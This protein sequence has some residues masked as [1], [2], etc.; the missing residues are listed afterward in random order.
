MTTITSQK[1]NQVAALLGTTDKNTVFTVVIG[2]LMEAGVDVRAAVDMVFGEGAY[3][4][5]A[6]DLYDSLR[7]A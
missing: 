5:M 6:G 7:A 4:K 1:L 3:T 2:T